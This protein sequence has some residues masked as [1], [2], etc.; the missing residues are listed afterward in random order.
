M[1]NSSKLLPI[2]KAASYL[3]VSIVTLRRWDDSGKLPALRR[4]SGY[5]YYERES[6]ERFRR[7]LF[8]I[9][10]LWASSQ[11]ASDISDDQYSATQDRFRA[12][13]DRM[14]V[15]IDRYTKN[16]GLASLVT[17]VAGEIGNNSFDHN[18]GNWPDVQGVFFA[19]D[20][21]KR[22]IV[23]ADRGVGIKAT[24]SRVRTNLKDDNEALE[25]AMTERL[26]GR[27]PEQRG[28]GLKFVVNVARDN[29]I[30]V[31]LQSGTANATIGKEDS[32]LKISLADRNVRGVLAKI[33][34]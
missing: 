20:V 31:S 21:N 14:A 10:I 5:R 16:S 28:N 25:V 17:A 12:R 29:L 19:Y 24:L 27:F 1:N 11:V 15:L 30:R 33:E 18:L 3:G 7:D 8:S 9:A 13:L 26:S 4:P 23:L 22:L 2:G 34:Y 32:Q 6:I